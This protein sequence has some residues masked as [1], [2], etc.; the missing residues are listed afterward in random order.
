MSS[1]NVFKYPR[2]I[3]NLISTSGGDVVGPGSATDNAIVRFNGITGTLIQNSGLGI[4]DSANLIDTNA[5][6]LINFTATASAVNEISITNAA[7]GTNPIIGVSGD[8]TNISLEYL[9]KGTG[10]HIFDNDTAA[11]E[12]RLRDDVGTDYIGIKASATTTSH[13]LTL[14]ATQ[15]AASTFLQNNGSGILS[16]A[17]AGGG[18]TRYICAGGTP[19][20]HKPS[21]YTVVYRFSYPGSTAA[22]TIQTVT[23]IAY[24]LGTSTY[25]IRVQDITNGT[26]IAE[27]T[28]QTN[29]TPAI[30]DLGTISNVPTGAAVFELQQNK[31]AG[32][33]SDKVSASFVQLEL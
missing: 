1:I 10:T 30:I 11:A 12:I 18:D 21:S 25:S 7:T 23:A 8:D 19:L 2:N 29:N 33:P 14:P 16:W 17:T 27:A 26:T 32:H 15:G 24:Q 22:G 9:T 31:T 5:N 13:T 28:G 4:N 6:E 3:E 20:T